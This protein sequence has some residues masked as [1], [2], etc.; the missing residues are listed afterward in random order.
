M[1]SGQADKQ[2]FACPGQERQRLHVTTPVGSFPANGT[3]PEFE[4]SGVGGLVPDR[5]EE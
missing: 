1:C 4:R 3:S 5:G 2:V